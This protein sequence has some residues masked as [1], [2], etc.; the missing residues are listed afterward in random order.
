MARRG[1]NIYHRKD[2]RWEGRCIV[3]RK[4]DGRPRFHS[5]YGKSY[6][7]VKKNLVLLKSKHVEQ[8]K[9]QT[10]LIYENG[11]LSDWM[12]YWLDVI[13]KPYIRATTYDLYRRNI[14][15]HLRP[16][17]GQYALRELSQTHVQTLVNR[18]NQTLASGTLHG[19]CRL[20]KAI[21]NSAVT[22]RLMAQS[23]YRDVRM[24]K[25]R[26]KQPR[27]LTVSE[28]M[29]LEQAVMESDRLEYLLCL[30]TGL[31]LGEL[32]ALRYEDIDFSSNMLNVT[33]SVK[34]I[35]DHGKSESATRLVVGRTKTESS[36]REIPLPF[37]LLKMLAD[38]MKQKGAA[39]TDYIFPSTKGTA[40]EPRTIQKQF[41]RL[42]KRIGI[43]G[44]HMHTLRHTFAMRC[45]EHGMGYK[46]LSEILGHSS[47][48]TTIRHYDNCTLEKKQKVMRNAQLIA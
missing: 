5:I 28:Q 20:L 18:L 33:H 23:P 45:L 11:S 26:K 37:F 4:T 9:E 32:C 10:I 35:T 43:R 17:L 42:T 31:R 12:D 48:E 46:A 16:H 38:R 24:P 29:R 2:G 47:S 40:A 22:N 21:L 44:A 36:E 6:S 14:D 15:K 39:K 27:V 19:I 1:E 30:Y 8:R 25:C 3:G 34:R 7:E 13:E 41:E